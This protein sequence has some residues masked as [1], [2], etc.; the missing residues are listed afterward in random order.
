[1]IEWLRWRLE[2]NVLA[3]VCAVLIAIA[4]AWLAISGVSFR[5]DDANGFGPD[6]ECTDHP[7]GGPTCIK[8]VK[9]EPSR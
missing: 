8:R 5:R 6:W 1:M 3:V 4:I 9:P 7:R 2:G